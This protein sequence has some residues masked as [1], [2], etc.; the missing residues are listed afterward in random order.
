M[1][2]SELIKILEKLKTKH[3]DIPVM[4]EWNNISDG[5][6]M[7][8]EADDYFNLPDHIEIG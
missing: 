6:I 2:I 7:F 4:F 5:E 8:A 3:G 1:K